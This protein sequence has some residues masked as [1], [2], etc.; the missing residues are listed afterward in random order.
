MFAKNSRYRTLPEVVSTNARG[1]KQITKDFR[2]VAPAAGE[3]RHVV[4]GADR[5][6]NVAFKYYDQPTKWWRISDANPDFM[7]P[8]A[9]LGM[10][11]I[12][13]ARFALHFGGAAA[14][15]TELVRRVRAL[16]GVEDIK[17]VEEFEIVAE[18][19]TV[20]GQTVT[21]NVEHVSRSAIVTYNR[22]N[23]GTEQLV[24]AMETSGFDVG[25]PQRIGRV[26]KEIVIPPDA[27]QPRS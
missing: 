1:R 2:D 25:E 4:A 10:E 20:G 15:W 23:V 21:V 12:D 9:L 26:G 17:V 24:G 5:L 11:P 6:D 3:F 18:E 27:A 14:P 7:S 19:Q 13:T 8:Q 16:V 22:M